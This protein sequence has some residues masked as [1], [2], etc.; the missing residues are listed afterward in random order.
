[1]CRSAESE[2]MRFT[3]PFSKPFAATT[4]GDT[5]GPCGALASERGSYPETARPWNSGDGSGRPAYLVLRYTARPALAASHLV[6]A[7]K[8][9]IVCGGL[10]SGVPAPLRPPRSS[11]VPR[12]RVLQRLHITFKSTDAARFAR[13]VPRSERSERRRYSFV[14]GRPVSPYLRATTSILSD[15]DVSP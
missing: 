8:T 13:R 7:I 11:S 12:S 15:R 6:T 10:C 14:R 1:M 2:R 3:L 9:A 5:P 4:P